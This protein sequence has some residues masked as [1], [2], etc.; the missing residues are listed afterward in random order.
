MSVCQHQV[1]EILRNSCDLV[2]QYIRL[3]KR[4]HI[5]FSPQL[6]AKGLFNLP[7]LLAARVLVVNEHAHRNAMLW[8]LQSLSKPKTSHR[9]SHRLDKERRAAGVHLEEAIRNRKRHQI[10]TTDS[11]NATQYR[12]E[13]WN[14]LM[15]GGNR[16]FTFNCALLLSSE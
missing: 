4:R 7:S 8:S 2:S 14:H 5:R 11:V 9:V 1:R 13:L 16:L 10:P 12:S 6:S 3:R 15:T